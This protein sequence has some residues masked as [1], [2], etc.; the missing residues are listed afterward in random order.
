MF[1]VENPQNKLA[2]WLFSSLRVTKT[3]GSSS[4]YTETPKPSVLKTSKFQIYL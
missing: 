1:R 3:K 2:A 4:Y